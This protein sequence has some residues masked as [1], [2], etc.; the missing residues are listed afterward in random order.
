MKFYSQTLVLQ[1]IEKLLK[2]D[3]EENW[4]NILI[5]LSILKEIFSEENMKKF[6][7][8]ISEYLLGTKQEES[9]YCWVQIL[10]LPF[11]GEIPAKF[12]RK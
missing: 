5:R 3:L 8:C 4:E 12:V 6:L 1:E 9:F 2:N 11:Q 10:K 7:T